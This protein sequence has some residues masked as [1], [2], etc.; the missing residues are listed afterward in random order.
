MSYLSTVFEKLVKFFRGILFFG[1][2][3]I[4]GKESWFI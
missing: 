1:T 3:S 4:K 2:P